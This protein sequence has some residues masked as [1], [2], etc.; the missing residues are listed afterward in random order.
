MSNETQVA[1]EFCGELYFPI[2][3]Y[4]YQELVDAFGDDVPG[5]ARAAFEEVAQI[6]IF[7]SIYLHHFEFDGVSVRVQSA[8]DWEERCLLLGITLGDP[9]TMDLPEDFPSPEQIEDQTKL[10]N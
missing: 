3:C 5:V 8:M 10:L 1:E 9:P 2:K 6:G 4:Y 7:N